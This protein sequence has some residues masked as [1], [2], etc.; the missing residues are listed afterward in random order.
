MCL[1]EQ[2]RLTLMVKWS[3]RI[4]EEKKLAYGRDHY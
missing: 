2:G 1:I 3:S 4:S